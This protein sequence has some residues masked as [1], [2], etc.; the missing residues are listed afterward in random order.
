MSDKY[1]PCLHDIVKIVGKDTEYIIVD[2]SSVGTVGNMWTLKRGQGGTI[3][4]PGHNLEFVRK[5]T[6]E[7]LKVLDEDRELYC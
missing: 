4:G 7:D 1:E 5:P 3:Y 2:F 6:E